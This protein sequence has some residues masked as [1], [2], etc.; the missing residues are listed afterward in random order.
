MTIIASAMSWDFAV[1][2]S[3][4]RIS[5]NGKPLDD[6]SN[7]ATIL[8][9]QNARFAVGYTGLAQW[10]SF[11]TQ[12]WIVR[13]LQECAAPDYSAEPLC[14][15]FIERATS[16]FRDLERLKCAPPIHKRLTI[17]LTGFGIFTNRES[18][19]S[20]SVP[21]SLI[22]T[23][24][25]DADRGVDD[26]EAWPEFKGTFGIP[27]PNTKV[28]SYVQRVGA[29]QAFPDEEVPVIRTLLAERKPP[30]AVV[31]KLVAAVRTAADRPASGN[32]IGKQVSS[33]IIPSDFNSP[34]TFGYHTSIDSYGYYVPDF[35][36]A[37]PGATMSTRDFEF[38]VADQQN[39][40]PILVPQQPRNSLCRCGSG[41][42]YK[43]CH[44]KNQ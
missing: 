18:G 41:K 4:R 14:K 17:M 38:K 27:K 39:A 30:Q 22:V 35:V 9:C 13:T 25:Q 23:N 36:C 28:V 32:G 6:E 34:I 10:S 33:A 7:K 40:A 44:G 2:V 29:W 5:W 26:P 16:D 31:G 19:K 21:L 15:R 8:I 12:D 1:Q 37:L 20:L 24:F 43:M 3:D 11:N 42:K